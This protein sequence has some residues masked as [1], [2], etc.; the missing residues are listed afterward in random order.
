MNKITGNYKLSKKKKTMES[1][2]YY[3]P[4][5]DHLKDNSNVLIID[6]EK[7]SR[8]VVRTILGNTGFQ[9][10]ITKNG[11]EATRMMLGSKQKFGFILINIKEGIGAGRLMRN[12]GYTNPII[13]YTDANIREQ[14]GL[15]RF[16]DTSS[17]YPI[18]TSNNTWGIRQTN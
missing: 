7:K 9:T 17:I 2:S 4:E 5:E 18:S 1:I 15:I 8:L 10:L 13:Y 16:P 11:T 14:R 3:I 12:C 6:C